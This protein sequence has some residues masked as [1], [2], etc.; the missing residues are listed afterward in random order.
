VRGWVRGGHLTLATLILFCD[1]TP[2]MTEDMRRGGGGDKGMGERRGGN[3]VLG[4][5]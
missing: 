4:K 5:L 2:Y 1:V 3:R